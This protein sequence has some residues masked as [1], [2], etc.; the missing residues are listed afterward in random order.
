ML[1]YALLPLLPCSC[2]VTKCLLVLADWWLGQLQSWGPVVAGAL[3]GA[4]AAHAR[5]GAH[6]VKAN[7]QP[8][9]AACTPHPRAVLTA[10]FCCL[11]T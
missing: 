11:L 1:C 9:A 4:G 2:A 6:K 5:C 3:F 10:M 7:V 8:G